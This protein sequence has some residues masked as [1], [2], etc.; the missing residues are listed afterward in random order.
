MADAWKDYF[1][2]YGNHSQ[3]PPWVHTPELWRLYSELLL[4]VDDLS[5]AGYLPKDPKHGGYKPLLDKIVSVKRRIEESQPTLRRSPSYS[6]AIARIAGKDAADRELAAMQKKL[7]DQIKVGFRLDSFLEDCKRGP[8]SRNR[9]LAAE[10]QLP[11]MYAQFSGQ[12]ADQP[13]PKDLPTSF[14]AQV[15]F[16][17]EVRVLGEQ[18]AAG[19]SSNELDDGNDYGEQMLPWIKNEVE[20]ADRL[21]RQ[22]E[23]L[24]FAGKEMEQKSQKN[25]ED[26]QRLY[27]GMADNVI[28]PLRQ[29]MQVRDE[30]LAKLPFYAR[31]ECHSLKAIGGTDSERLGW[32]AE[33]TRLTESVH[34]LEKRLSEKSPSELLSFDLATRARL[35]TDIKRLTDQAKEQHET[36]KT[37][38]HSERSKG[39]EPGKLGLSPN[40]R[41][42]LE[43]LLCLPLPQAKD[44][45]AAVDAREKF[46]AWLKDP[47]AGNPNKAEENPETEKEVVEAE[48]KL[49]LALVGEDGPRMSVSPWQKS[50]QEFSDTLH[51]LNKGNND[52]EKLDFV[53]VVNAATVQ[54]FLMDEGS[55]QVPCLIEKRRRDLASLL[56][57]EG[58]RIYADYWFDV[59]DNGKSDS[60]Y[61]AR[62]LAAC[63]ED[64]KVLD[65]NEGPD[66]LVSVRPQAFWTSISPPNDQDYFVVGN[67]RLSLTYQAHVSDT[68]PLPG[69]FTYNYPYGKEGGANQRQVLL[70]DSDTTKEL[71]PPP[72][73]WSATQEK[74]G[75]QAYFRGRSYRDP[76]NIRPLNKPQIAFGRYGT[77]EKAGVSVWANSA[78]RLPLNG[79]ISIV[80]D[81][82]GSMK[83]SPSTGQASKRDQ[84]VKALK[85]VLLELG[86]GPESQSG[87][88]EM[89][90][91]VMTAQSPPLESWTDL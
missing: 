52:H 84:M 1:E 82:S 43:G 29:A 38:L 28:E 22:G 45:V 55:K 20:I 59:D 42:E 50:S 58:A 48:R 69:Y 41:L 44:A 27:K 77:V 64:A 90:R 62:G 61:Y 51:G 66:K 4:R 57:W 39:L 23:D 85:E 46:H 34:R 3:A 78:L 30:I 72:L 31:W 37:R 36:L 9:D 56:R 87:F 74:I 18:V 40:D 67:E 33:L 8:R 75:F 25:L 16:A 79:K 13:L 11:W 60:P 35:V 32:L 17:K 91:R 70:L 21:R 15:V 26:A 83:D 19:A 76:R 68:K 6:H 5:R 80:L 53:R 89:G 71:S 2:F 14:P 49:M 81:Y 88:L 47:H 24:L 10:L 12:F 65:T 7:L 73:D 86:S 63:L 54:K